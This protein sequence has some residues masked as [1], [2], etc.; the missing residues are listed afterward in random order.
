MCSMPLLFFVYLVCIFWGMISFAQDLSSV[1][2]DIMT[3]VLSGQ[4]GQ[5]EDFVETWMSQEGI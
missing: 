2:D 3:P 1:L 4:D 5:H